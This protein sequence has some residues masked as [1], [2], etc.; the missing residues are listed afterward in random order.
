[1]IRMQRIP[2][3]INAKTILLVDDDEDIRL[4]CERE[5]RKEGYHTRSFSSG[6]D[7]IRF[8]EEK[9]QVDL[10]VLDIKMAPLNGMQVLQ[11]LRAK[12]ISIPVILYSDYAYFKRRFSTW[13]ADA[14]LVK[15]SDLT[16]LKR[17]IRELL[18]LPAKNRPI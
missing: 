14:F 11:A 4:M 6:P 16:E 9:P 1:M 7:I 18:T 3:V 12:N 13:L 2:I 15:S 17:K 8:M 5:L 10:I